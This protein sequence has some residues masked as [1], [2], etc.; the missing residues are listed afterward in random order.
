M[1]DGKAVAHVSPTQIGMDV[2]LIKD[3]T[4]KAFGLEL[5]NGASEN[6]I[7]EVSYMFPRPG[8]DTTPVQK[9]SFVTR[10]GDLGCG[11]GYYK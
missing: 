9:V 11:V 10:V 7:T 1:N 6:L 4:G 2:R 5:Y 8:A 3:A